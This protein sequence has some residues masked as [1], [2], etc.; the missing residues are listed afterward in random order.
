MV[1]SHFYEKAVGQADWQPH[2]KKH[3]LWCWWLNIKIIIITTWINE[4]YK[5][6]Q[7]QSKDFVLTVS[8]EK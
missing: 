8:E 6:E 2:Y 7:Y 5:V 4:Q 3:F 1:F